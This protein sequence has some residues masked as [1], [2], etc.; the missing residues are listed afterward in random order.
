MWTKM[1][2][3]VIAQSNHQDYQSFY[4][5]GIIILPAGC[6]CGGFVNGIALLY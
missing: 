3:V 2:S 4:P 1:V 6:L 5:Q